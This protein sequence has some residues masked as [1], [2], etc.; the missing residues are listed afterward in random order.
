MQP[1]LAASKL[2]PPSRLITSPR[3][4]MR[5]PAIGELVRRDFYRE[6]NVTSGG[7]MRGVTK[8]SS[9]WGAAN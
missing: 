7:E 4:G 3:S 5:S 2:V 6:T 8:Q 1:P 9:S